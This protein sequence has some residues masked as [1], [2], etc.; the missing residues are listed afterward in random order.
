M[1]SREGNGDMNQNLQSRNPIKK[2][3]G[4][5]Q[6]LQLLLRTSFYS[7]VPPCLVGAA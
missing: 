1:T 6:I 5:G 3:H 2:S 7:M 4:H